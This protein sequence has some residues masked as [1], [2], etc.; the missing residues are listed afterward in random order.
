VTTTPFTAMHALSEIKD[1]IAT[2]FRD[3][4]FIVTWDF[5][6]RTGLHWYEIYDGKELLAQID[7]GAPL[8]EIKEDLPQLAYGRS[9]TSTGP[10]LWEVRGTLESLQRVVQKMTSR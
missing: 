1:E 6:K 4:G 7:F 3:L 9:A 2:Y 8:A 5:D 10:V